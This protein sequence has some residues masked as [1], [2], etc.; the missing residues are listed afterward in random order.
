MT[1]GEAEAASPRH[2]AGPAQPRTPLRPALQD[3]P[4]EGK[5]GQDP[6]RAGK[7]GAPLVSVSEASGPEQ[8]RAGR[9]VLEAFPTDSRLTPRCL[10]ATHVGTGGVPAL[11]LPGSPAVFPGGQARLLPGAI[12]APRRHT[13]ARPDAATWAAQGPAKSGPVGWAK[14]PRGAPAP[15]PKYGPPF[16]RRRAPTS[17]IGAFRRVSKPLRMFV[18]FLRKRLRAVAKTN[19][20]S[21]PRAFSAYRT[22]FWTDRPATS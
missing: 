3:L 9:R 6:R 8:T 5:P 11:G 21:K 22:F 2:V 10:G 7:P 16:L 4:I 18:L 12:R 17:L 13:L 14:R 19:M 1:P 20:N 15:P